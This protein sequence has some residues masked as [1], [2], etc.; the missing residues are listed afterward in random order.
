MLTNHNLNSSTE[1]VIIGAGLCGMIMALYL[2]RRGYF[3]ELYEKANNSIIHSV[4]EK[5]ATELDLSKRALLALSELGLL[6][7]VIEKAVPTENRILFYSDQTKIQIQHG[8]DKDHIIYNISRADLYT[9]LFSAIQNVRNIKVNFSHKLVSADLKQRHLVFEKTNAN[10][11][12]IKKYSAALGCDGVNS[13]L[14]HA[15]DATYKNN[16]NCPYV[17]KEITLP[18]SFS[19]QNLSIK[20]MYKWIGDKIIFFAHPK[21]NGSFNGTLV[22]PSVLGKDFSTIFTYKNFPQ[23]ENIMEH[24]SNEFKHQSFSNL[25]STKVN[26]QQKEGILLLGDAAHGMLPFLGQGVN[27]AF[28]DCRLFN[29]QLDFS[30]NNWER[31]IKDFVKRRQ[32]DTNAIIDMSEIEYQEFDLGYDA[33]K[34]QFSETLKVQLNKRYHC[35]FKSYRHLLAFTHLPYAK[36]KNINN[37]NVKFCVKFIIILKWFDVFNGIV[38]IAG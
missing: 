28:E 7:Q 11:F 25:K 12:I 1:V 36:L 38:L 19:M 34:N 4:P 16:E 32:I 8:F 2:A 18:T 33:R 30:Q 3:I 13:T 37:F 27:C 15:V 24:L 35:L 22:L 14:R 17:Y 6:N 21:I 23:F 29:Q 31:A 9:I 20:S 26:C 10:D 5:R